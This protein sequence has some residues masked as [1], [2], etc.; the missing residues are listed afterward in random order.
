MEGELQNSSTRI[1]IGRFT[2]LSEFLCRS[3]PS[4]N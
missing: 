1:F 4:S 2:V 3:I